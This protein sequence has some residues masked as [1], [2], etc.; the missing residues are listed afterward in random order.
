MA[1]YLLQHMVGNTLSSLIADY[2]LTKVADD[3]DMLSGDARVVDAIYAAKDVR[4]R[5]TL[6]TEE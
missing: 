3:L 1:R 5:S 2:Y 6:K 4:Q